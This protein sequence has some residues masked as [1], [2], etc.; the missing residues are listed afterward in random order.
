[1]YDIDMYII[2]IKYSHFRDMKTSLNKGIT[3][4]QFF[5]Y[6]GSSFFILYIHVLVHFGLHACLILVIT[7]PH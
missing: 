1:M 2:I 4:F 6:R 7:L 3:A 5:T